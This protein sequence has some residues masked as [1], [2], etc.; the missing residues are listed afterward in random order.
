MEGFMF[1]LQKAAMCSV[2]YWREYKTA[3]AQ[4]K[5]KAFNLMYSLRPK[6][7]HILNKLENIFILCSINYSRH[8]MNLWILLH[9]SGNWGQCQGV[10][11]TTHVHLV[12]KL[13]I[14]RFNTFNP[15]H[16][17][18]RCA[19]GPP[20]PMKFDVCEIQLHNFCKGGCFNPSAWQGGGTLLLSSHCGIS[21]RKPWEGVKTALDC[22]SILTM[23]YGIIKICYVPHQGI[24][25]W[26]QKIASTKCGP[27]SKL[28]GSVI[29]QFVTLLC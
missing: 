11:L 1:Q 15:Q 28:L 27:L 26:P 13:R 10:R 17:P 7:K 25:S 12:L 16:I 4:P 20:P 22:C 21:H 6:K 29:K 8:H 3:P 5:Q 19:M 23:H 9:C 14:S 24:I 18:S 2:M